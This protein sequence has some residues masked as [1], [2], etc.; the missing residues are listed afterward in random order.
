LSCLLLLLVLLVVLLLVLVVL[1]SL[2]VALLLLL[3]LLQLAQRELE[4]A[5]RVG[6][7][8]HRVERVAVGLHRA[9]V[10]LLLEQAVAEV[11]ARRAGEGPTSRRRRAT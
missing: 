11:V 4:V 6:V 1:L 5:P 8:G 10:V 2:L 3:L 9:L 7:A